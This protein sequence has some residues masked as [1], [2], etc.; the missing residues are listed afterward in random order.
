MKRYI[1]Y[2]PLNYT[3]PVSRR[4]VSQDTPFFTFRYQAI[5]FTIVYIL[6]KSQFDTFN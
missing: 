4:S 3:V 6:S 2:K 1:H 5:M